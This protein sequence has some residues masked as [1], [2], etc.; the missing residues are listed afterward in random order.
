[1]QYA[2][3]ITPGEITVHFANGDAFSWPKDHL[4]FNDV[5]DALR[6]S[7]PADV[8]LTLMDTVART[9]E[10]LAVV[11][12]DIGLTVSRDGV[13]WRGKALH[14]TVTDRIVQFINEDLP[15]KP[16]VSFL[17]KLLKNHRREAVL[18]LFDFLEANKIPITEDGDFVVY[19]R[20]KDDYMDI[21]SGTIDNHVG[22]KPSVEPWE[23]DPD[24]DNTCSNGLH[25]CSREYLPSFGS[26]SRDRIVICKVNPAAVVAVPRDYNNSKM[27]VFEYEV[28]GELSDEQKANLLD[29]VSLLRRGQ[30][31][32]DSFTWGDNF[33]EDESEV[34]QDSTA[35][36]YGDPGP[37]VEVEEESVEICPE[38]GDETSDGSYCDDC[39][40][41]IN[42]Q[43]EDD[44]EQDAIAQTEGEGSV[45]PDETPTDEPPKKTKWF[46]RW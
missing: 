4:H 45:T 41:D 28:I 30:S 7:A 36:A 2:A 37:F 23:V 34:T 46:G 17:E 15:V 19:K 5:K 44:N 43:N 9:K 11:P 6:A 12:D 33:Q 35:S 32:D 14:M 20:V 22:K 26:A 16:L 13:F 29:E 42:A 1:M 25:V 39:E 24:R 21:H 3:S 18:S 27:R 40:E 38:C 10:A 31:V 8:L